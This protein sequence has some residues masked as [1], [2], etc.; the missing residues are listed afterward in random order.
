[1]DPWFATANCICRAFLPFTTFP[2]P[3]LSGEVHLTASLSP[4]R[5]SYKICSYTAMNS[6]PLPWLQ[7]AVQGPTWPAEAIHENQLGANPTRAPSFPCKGVYEQLEGQREQVGFNSFHSRGILQTFDFLLTSSW[8]TWAAFW[9][10]SLA[11]K[12]KPTKQKRG[13]GVVREEKQRQKSN[14]SYPL[15]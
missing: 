7:Q 2:S 5:L 3:F 14:Y 13:R 6:L 8:A 12:K 15:T 9:S 4:F 10:A 1:M 11:W